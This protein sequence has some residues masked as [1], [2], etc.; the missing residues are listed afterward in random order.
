M[1]LSGQYLYLNNNDSTAIVRGGDYNDLS[2]LIS[3]KYFLEKSTLEESS[4]IGFRVA[5]Y[6]E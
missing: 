1:F 6:L 2:N 5:L 4:T 3:A